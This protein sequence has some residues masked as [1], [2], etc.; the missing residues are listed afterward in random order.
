MTRPLL[1]ALLA[2]AAR[3]GLQT[4]EPEEADA[5]TVFAL[6]R[7][8]PYRRA[9]DRRPETTIR[10]WRGTC[11][12]KH[13]LL[14]ALLEEL[15]HPTT[16]MACTAYVPPE[17]APRLPPRLRA[18]LEAGPVPDVH[19]YLRVEGPGGAQV[20]DATWPLEAAALGI[21]V[22]ESLDWG[23]DMLLPC[24]P[25]EELP[26]PADVDPQRFKEELLRARFSAEELDRR[27]AFFRAVAG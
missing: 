4:A 26:V 3:R 2:E 17:L 24:E 18:L 7:E 20:V 5:Q 15:G 21:P 1:G 16:L 8:M 19:N 9:S 23:R 14:G 6:V 12:G 13:Y 10:E 22:N 27:E 25:L 11:S